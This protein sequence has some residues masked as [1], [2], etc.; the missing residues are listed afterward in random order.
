MQRLIFLI[1]IFLLA[2]S[3]QLTYA[4]TSASV[5][6]FCENSTSAIV[7]F[8]NGINN[9]EEEAK[10]SQRV[11]RKKIKAV[12]SSDQFSK[13]E[14]KLAYNKTYGFMSDLYESLEQ[15]SGSE[16]FS[17]LFWRWMGNL[18]VLPD[19]LQDIFKETTAYF[20]VSE[21]YGTA[22][23]SNHLTL[24]RAGIAEGKTVLA[25]AHS[26]GN[27]FANAAFQE[28]YYGS[29][30]I[31]TQSFG[32]V[33]AANPSSF[34]AGDGP[35]TTLA[36]DLIIH[37]IDLASIVLADPLPPNVTNLGGASG[38][39]WASHNFVSAYLVQSSRSEN[40]ILGD[41]VSSID[42]LEAPDQIA[43]DGIITA[44]LTWGSQPDV[45]LHVFEPDATH[46]YYSHLVGSYGYLDVD[47]VSGFGPEHYFVNCN[48]LE[49]GTYRVSVNY[50]YGS[51]FE[52]ALV[53]IKAG[54]SIRSFNQ[55]LPLS[56]GTNGD[57]SPIGIAEIIVSGN[58][59]SGFEFNI[60]SLQ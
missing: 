20:D 50:F 31:Q 49:A 3:Q 43:Q 37:A 12:L 35:Y 44:T 51:G 14:F 59:A 34:V 26:Q 58:A 9:T 53:Q 28:L 36:E 33:S 47:D 57:G 1:T 60:Q 46:V 25:V 45:D 41:I 40:K 21:H 2:S 54:N 30:P 19:D 8:V 5:N 11:L 10:K 24:Y 15:K 23:L 32:I 16:N 4:Y 13:L 39:D 42:S 22:D 29:N 18:D 48:T 55:Y 52:E 6:S 27:F 56:Q 7:V 17:S 38:Q